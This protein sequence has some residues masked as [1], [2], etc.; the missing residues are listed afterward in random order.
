MVDNTNPTLRRYEAAK[1][2]QSLVRE[3]YRDCYR[4]ALPS[5]DTYDQTLE[6]KDKS[7]DLFDST[8]VDSTMRFANTINSAVTPPE[9]KWSTW[10]AGSDVPYEERENINK[11]LDIANDRFFEG[12]WATNFDAVAPEVYM[13]LAVGTGSML[14]Q[15][16]DW[17]GAIYTP[18][19]AAQLVIEEGPDGTVYTG[20]VFW[21]R[22]IKLRDL[23]YTYNIKSLP[24]DL[25]KA[26][27]TCPDE[28]VNV[29]DA[30]CWQ[31]NDREYNY[32]VFVMN[33]AVTVKFKDV[34]VKQSTYEVMPWVVTR[35]VKAAGEHYGRGPLT[36]CI[37]DI[38]TLNRTVELILQNAS[39]AI[40]GVYTAADDGVLNPNTVELAPGVVIPVG[41]NGGVNG[42]S[43]DVL[44][45][46]GD[47]D[48][49]DLVLKDLR[50]SIR[51]K[52]Y[53][54]T[55]PDTV[56]S[57]EEIRMLSKKIS[58]DIGSAWGRIKY[59][60][61]AGVVQRTA[62]IF[63]KQ[64]R[65][66]KLKF[67]GKYV[68]IAHRSPLAQYQNEEELGNFR[69][70]I[71]DMSLIHPQAGMVAID[72]AKTLAWIGRKHSLPPSLL[73]PEAKMTQTLQQVGQAMGQQIA[74]GADPAKMVGGAGV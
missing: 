46:S 74:R 13:D 64:G 20:A 26:I 41:Y 28:E 48:V 55:S 2:R 60:M 37:A 29:L 34:V 30:V 11:L 35:W 15:D 59:E 61:I 71:S 17:K 40:A 65:L 14:I 43:L 49:G 54:T 67:D 8:A 16:D 69:G 72:T 1:R 32:E 62:H 21:E 56:R 18:V 42:R 9:Y 57:A 50:S 39:L 36:N 12:L 19:P 38:K 68:K 53:D 10:E 4:Y 51:K 33:K 47:F 63:A 5:R 45:R 66:P 23:P 58:E 24:E 44:P 31:P 25:N 22:R 3:L 70:A 27:E 7:A 52:L 73:N 6:G